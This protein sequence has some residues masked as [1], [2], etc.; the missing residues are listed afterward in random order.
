MVGLF[1]PA[2]NTGS[3]LTPTSDGRWRAERVGFLFLE[4]DPAVLE[5]DLDLFL[6]QV[7]RVGDLDSTEAGQ[8]HVRRELPFQIEELATVEGRSKTL[9]RRRSVLAVF[10][11]NA[12]LRR[13]R[14]KT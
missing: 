13:R 2:L 5:P 9:Q 6:G 1:P 14:Y 10:I 7:K 4:L 3:Q 8:V 11:V 12:V